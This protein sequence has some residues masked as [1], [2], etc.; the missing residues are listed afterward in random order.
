MIT[1]YDANHDYKLSLEEFCELFEHE[2]TEEDNGENDNEEDDNEENDNEEDNNGETTEL[3]TWLAGKN[4]AEHEG[5]C[6][7]TFR[8]EW[9]EGAY[10]L[11]SAH[12]CDEY[13]L[14]VCVTL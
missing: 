13:E 5:E 12:D 14:T 9:V 4:I 8:I 1:Q 3:D 2:L 6:V 11:W 7:S 10:R